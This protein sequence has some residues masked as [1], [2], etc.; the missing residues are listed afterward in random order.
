LIHDYSWPRPDGDEFADMTEKEFGAYYL[1][2]IPKAPELSLIVL[3]E[4]QKKCYLNSKDWREQKNIDF[5]EYVSLHRKQKH[6][7]LLITQIMDN[8]DGATIDLRSETIWLVRWDIM[9]WLFKNRV[10]EKHYLETQTLRET[11]YNQITRKYSP[12]MYDLYKSYTAV[13]KGEEIRKTSTIF[14]NKK[15]I[16]FLLVGVILFLS[17]LPNFLRTINATGKPVNDPKVYLGKFED[18]ECADSLY[19]LRQDGKIDVILKNG[20]PSY[21][22]PRYGYIHSVHSIYA[23]PKK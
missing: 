23:R 7:L 10:S 9:G 3:D 22:C 2:E 8:V 21:V 19:V 11:P 20:V 15:I 17:T 16:G 6:E 5:A 13:T 1:K 14:Q 18:Y 12:L 4:C